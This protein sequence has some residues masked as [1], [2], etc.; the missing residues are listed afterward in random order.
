[1]G[2]NISVAILELFLAENE[3]G[4]EIEKV[5]SHQNLSEC[6]L[7]FIIFIQKELQNGRRK[8]LKIVCTFRLGVR[9][10]MHVCAHQQFWKGQ[11]TNLYLS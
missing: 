8:L 9:V 2:K 4:Y 3:N 5:S 10:C 6:G 1:M 7:R 11:K